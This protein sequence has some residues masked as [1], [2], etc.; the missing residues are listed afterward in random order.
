VSDT[1]HELD[2]IF[3]DDAAGELERCGIQREVLE[4]SSLL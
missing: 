4:C 1:V 3:G 2:G